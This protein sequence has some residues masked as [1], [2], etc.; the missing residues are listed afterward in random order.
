MAGTFHAALLASCP[1]VIVPVYGGQ[2][3]WADAA[4]TLG[5]G[6]LNPVSL[7]Q[8]TPQLLMQVDFSTCP[9]V[10]RCPS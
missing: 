1:S 7:Q 10:F 6:P 4:A 5:I 9:L 8:L 2:M 3:F